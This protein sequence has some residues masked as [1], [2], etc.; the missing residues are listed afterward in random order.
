[1]AMTRILFFS[2]F[3]GALLAQVTSAAGNPL[4]GK[5]IRSLIGGKTILLSTGYGFSLPLHYEL[6]GDVTGDG[7][8][9]MLGRF[10]A[11][12]ETG[13]WWVENNLLCQKW[14]S[15]YEGRKFCFSLRQTGRQTIEW[16][17]NDGY[18]GTAVISG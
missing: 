12:K 11:P 7:R 18:S 1:M 8:G 17:R 14:P 10:F 9:T 16:R 4:G 3:A 6:D 2:I 15:W 13:K 5:E